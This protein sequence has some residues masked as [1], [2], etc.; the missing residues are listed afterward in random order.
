[1]NKTRIIF[2]AFL[3]LALLT[4]TLPTSQARAAGAIYYVKANAV[5]SNDGSSWANAYTDLQNALAASVSGDEIWVA[6]GTYKPTSSADRT[7]SFNLK[8]GVAVYGGFVG[9]ETLRTERNWTA[10]LTFLSGNLGVAGDVNDNSYHVVNGSN[11][12]DAVLDGFVVIAGNDSAPPNAGGGIYITQSHN[13]TLANLTVTT[14]QAK[15]GGGL[16]NFASTGLTLTHITFTNN[17]AE[18]GGGFSNVNSDTILTDIT[19]NNN[20]AYFAGGGMK[21]LANNG[22]SNPTLTNVVFNKNS[23]FAGGAMI[24]QISTSTTYDGLEANVIFTN[25]VFSDNSGYLGGALH[26]TYFATAK[27]T[28][29]TFKNNTGRLGGGILND[30]RANIEIT[31]ATFNGNSTQQGGV[32]AIESNTGDAILKNVTFRSNSAERETGWLSASGSSLKLIN[33]TASGNQSADHCGL[34]NNQSTISIENSILWGNDTEVCGSTTSIQNSIVQGGCTG[35]PLTCSNVLDDNPLLGAL[36]DNGGFTK[37]LALGAGSPAIDKASG[38]ACPTTDQ[39]GVTRAQGPACDMGAYEKDQTAVTF[40]AQAANDGWILESAKG[41]GAG[42][43]MNAAAASFPVGDDATDRQYRA[44]LSFNTAS[45][46]IPAGAVLTGARLKLKSQSITGANP[47]SLLGDLLIDIRKG[48][49]GNA[50]TLELRDFKSAASQDAI[51]SITTLPS[52]TSYNKTWLKSILPNI[53]T[54]GVTQ[55]RLRFAQDTN[56]D[57]ISN[58]IN[59][60][61]GDAAAA[62]RPQLVVYYYVP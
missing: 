44:I 46:A 6:K 12:T 13:L 21:N 55:F 42:G 28:N 40:N 53:N 39:R 38:A 49:F 26:N 48:F 45:P 30:A 51:G 56:N 37:T 25:V 16:Y 32:I 8:D 10:N 29:A 52:G 54:N 62:D 35:S 3:I 36:A 60:Y 41:S 57:Q 14:N 5:G 15:Q 18:Y 4:S 50:A 27:L 31:N 22:K 17:G 11:V 2:Y 59:F 61:S 9:T 33:I 43:S 19:F 20:S 23:S 24:N 34:R 1:M 47:F 7:V 58:A